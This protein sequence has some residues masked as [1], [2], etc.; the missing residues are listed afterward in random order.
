MSAAHLHKAIPTLWICQAPDLLGG[1]ANHT[2]FA[3]LVHELHCVTLVGPS[4][5]VRLGSGKA[6]SAGSYPCISSNAAV[7]SPSIDSMRNC[8]CACSSLIRLMANPT[9]TRT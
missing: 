7:S 5:Q 1:F 3:E 2:S 4:G 8:S 9:W 6:G